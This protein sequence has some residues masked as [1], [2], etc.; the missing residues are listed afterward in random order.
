MWFEVGEY[1]Y[2][3]INPL[4]IHARC[5][6]FTDCHSPSFL[7]A[8]PPSTTPYIS[9]L[10]PLTS[11]SRIAVFYE[12]CHLELSCLPCES[13]PSLEYSICVTFF[14][15]CCEMPQRQP[16]P[17][18]VVILLSCSCLSS[19]FSV[20]CIVSSTFSIRCIVR[21][22]SAIVVHMECALITKEEARRGGSM[23]PSSWVYMSDNF[24]MA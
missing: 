23:R 8:P 7:L 1:R 9:I 16:A 3:Q 4:L 24:L 13:F 5:L 14:R 20:G 22:P 17:F 10:F 11:D 19:T 15:N 12:A 18:L 2:I 6:V 21:H